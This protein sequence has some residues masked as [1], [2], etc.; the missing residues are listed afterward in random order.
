MKCQTIWFVFIIG[1]G[2]FPFAGYGMARVP[3]PEQGKIN[4]K[5][6]ETAPE[7][8]EIN[9]KV[10]DSEARVL[11]TL[12]Q[13]QGTAVARGTTIYMYEVGNITVK[14]GIVLSVPYGFEAAM[15]QKNKGLVLY[16]SQWVTPEEK[17]KL[18]GRFRLEEA[19]REE[20]RLADIKYQKEKAD[21]AKVR[22]EREA[23][24]DA[25][26]KRKAAEDKRRF[27]ERMELE[28]IKQADRDRWQR[29][30]R[31]HFYH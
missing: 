8:D 31:R 2:C 1:L 25:E 10:G 5:A 26:K 23:K 3:V 14:D 22:A 4:T 7:L 11:E 15:K 30:W 28:K 6:R 9:I 29:S 12:G 17:I 13:P 24:E 16:R 27:D 21:A 20:K 19:A 18:E